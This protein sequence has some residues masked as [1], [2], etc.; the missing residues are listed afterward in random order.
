M[1][2]LTKTDPRVQQFAATFRRVLYVT[3]MTKDYCEWLR[4]DSLTPSWLKDDMRG[5][6]N[7][8]NRLIADAKFKTTPES[9]ELIRSDL[10]KEQVKDLAELIDVCANIANISDVTN[11]IKESKLV[12]E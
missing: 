9:F 3:D 10:N 2:N 5:I 6:I 11:I 7:A 8:I 1:T 12:C 4:M